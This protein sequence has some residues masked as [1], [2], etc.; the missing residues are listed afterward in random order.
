MHETSTGG[1][2]R[3]G[4]LALGLALPAAAV[5]GGARARTERPAQA[6]NGGRRRLGNLEVS[7]VGLGVQN[8]QPDLPNDDSA[9]EPEMINII[10]TAHRPRRYVL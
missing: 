4:I 6:T 9:A 3:R 10:R 2:G 5:A 1:L 8:M 7:S